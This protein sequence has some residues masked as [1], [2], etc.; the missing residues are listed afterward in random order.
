M[1][2]IA[3]F[4]AGPQSLS[5]HLVTENPTEAMLSYAGSLEKRYGCKVTVYNIGEHKAAIETLIAESGIEFGYWSKATFFRL[6]LPSILPLDI[7]KIL[8][9]D[10]DVIVLRDVSE[11][12]AF[13]M[14]G[15]LAAGVRDPSEPKDSVRIGTKQYFNAGVLLMRLD[16]WRENEIASKCFDYLADPEK[17]KLYLDQDAINY[18]LQDSIYGLSKE[19]NTQVTNSFTA[20][21]QLLSNLRQ[22]IFILHYVTSDKPWHAWYKSPFGEYYWHYLTV[23]PWKHILT[24]SPKTINEYRLMAIKHSE[25]GRLTDAIAIYKKIVDHFVLKK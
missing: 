25:A 12:F 14:H 6:L 15:A 16:L 10:S 8:Y 19:W 5:L 9:L 2:V 17:S 7:M 23:S 1:S 18:V 20:T 22:Y 24:E 4:E 21:D 3:N 11:V 13:E